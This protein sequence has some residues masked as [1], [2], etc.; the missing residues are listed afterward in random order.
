MQGNQGTFERIE[1]KYLLSTAQYEALTAACYG[2]LIQDH[3]GLHTIS[4]LYLDTEDYALIRASIEKPVYKEKMRIR[5]YGMARPDSTVFVE[6]KKKYDGIVYKRRVPMTLAEMETYFAR[7]QHPDASGQ[8]LREIDYFMD[9]YGQ[10]KPRAFIAYE[11]VA[12]FGAEDAGLRVT[13]DTNVRY[14]GQQLDLTHGTW[15]VELLG[16]DEV[17]MEVKAP[18]AIPVWLCEIFSALR[19]RPVSYSKYGTAYRMLI[20]PACFGEGLADAV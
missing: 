2:R 13:F 3:Y 20:Q 11:R 14:R 15:G 17:L 10:P 4:N 18:G 12:L 16:R 5:S 6:L 19:I 8:I 1:K 9:F 7:G